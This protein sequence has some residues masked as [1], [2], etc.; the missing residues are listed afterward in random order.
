VTWLELVKA[1]HEAPDLW[2][3]VGRDQEI[4]AAITDGDQ[5]TPFTDHEQEQIALQ[6]HELREL[7]RG[8]YHLDG[9]PLAELEERI[10]YLEAA[11]R[12]LGRID[13]RQILVSQLFALVARAVLPQDAFQEA[14]Q[15]LAH[16][17]GHLFGGGPPQLPG[18]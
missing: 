4:V 18:L 7:L 9:A 16:G 13:W 1:E 5:N 17:L 2:A 11:S 14:V 15:F 3:E 10:S 8:R 12:R 6:L